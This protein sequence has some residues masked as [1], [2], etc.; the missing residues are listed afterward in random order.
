MISREHE[1]MLDL[2]KSEEIKKDAETESKFERLT[3][4]E[5]DEIAGGYTCKNPNN[6]NC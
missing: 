5:L 6:L 4:D 3:D 2:N 1:K